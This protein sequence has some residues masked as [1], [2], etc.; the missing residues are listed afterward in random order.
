MKTLRIILILTIVTSF[1]QACKTL[2]LLEDNYEGKYTKDP[3][4]IKAELKCEENN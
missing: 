2:K 3:E 1:T 4:K